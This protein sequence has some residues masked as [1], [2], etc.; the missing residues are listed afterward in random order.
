[1][2]PGYPEITQALN[3]LNTIAGQLQG[4]VEPCFDLAELRGYIIIAEWFLLF[5]AR[6]GQMLLHLAVAMMKLA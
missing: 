3:D 5:T 4:M 2:L 6:V 1:L